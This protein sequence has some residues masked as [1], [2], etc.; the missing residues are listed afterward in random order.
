MEN[1]PWVLHQPK[2]PSANRVNTSPEKKNTFYPKVIEKLYLLIND[3]FFIDL[4]YEVLK[5]SN[6]TN[7]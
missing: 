4:H 1:T 3:C 2:K 5:C 7:T 6:N